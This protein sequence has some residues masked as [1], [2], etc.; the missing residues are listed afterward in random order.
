MATIKHDP[1]TPGPV[2]APAN[3]IPP[4]R[5]GDRL[6]RDEFERRYD[7]M[8]D[9]KKAEL[10]EGVVYVGSPVRQRHHGLP[11][12]TIMAWLGLYWSETPGT[13]PGDNSSI[14]L[15]MQNEPQGDAVL[16]IDPAC[17]GRV[18]IS[19]DDYIE[20]G[21]ELVVEVAASNVNYDVN[22]K[23]PIYLRNGVQEYVIWRVDE[24]RVDWFVRHGG[25]YE[26][27][28]PNTQGWYRSE[29]FP[30]LWL[31]PEALLRG[32]IAAVLAVV[33]QGLASP[34]HAAFV[35]RL[36]QTRPGGAGATP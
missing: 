13:E 14:R 29:V 1:T 30:G 35:S 15:D 26:P 18:R 2:A 24:R 8:P 16:F 28:L 21:P 6:T 4:L 20:G 9:L 7:A 32:D 36:Q 31:D 11:H 23:Q 10:I 34:E 3:G 33:R 19:A 22:I 25:R 12:A 17:G 5:T 27:L